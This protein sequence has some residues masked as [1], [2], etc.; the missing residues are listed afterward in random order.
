M[1]MSR[2]E[3]LLN[4]VRPTQ[5]EL[6]RQANEEPKGRTRMSGIYELLRRDIL[7]CRLKPGVRL[8]F[9]ELRALYEIGLSPL[10]E[11][12]MKL[13]SDGLVVLE[14]HK[15]FRVAPVSRS[16]LL[17]ITFMRKEFDAM[18]VRLSIE[19]GDDAWESSI[20]ASL[21]ELS[22]KP[23]LG[24][25]GLVDAE[26]EKRHRAFHLTLVSAC[27]SP[28]MLHFREQLYDQADRYRRLSV[29]YLREPRDHLA[30]HREIAEAALARDSDAAVFLIRRH[31][32]RTVQILLA[33]DG[34][35]SAEL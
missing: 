1:S 24:P 4:L 17:D 8:R 21:H 14:E 18:G 22:K 20:L 26:W 16:D 13:A 9:E 6:A 11:A 3:A 7:E 12:L 33:A 30:E 2:M 31:L 29:Q 25:D 27:G 28:W 19:K 5:R 34:V 32:D 15:G 35:L 23:K 10:R